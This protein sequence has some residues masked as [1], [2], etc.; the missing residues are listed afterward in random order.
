MDDW[1]I[2][3]DLLENV[4]AVEQAIEKIEYKM[5]ERIN[6]L[7]TLK[8]H[9]ML[10]KHGVLASQI[11]SYNLVAPR[12]WDSLGKLTLRLKDESRDPVEI[13]L[14][15][16][17]YISEAKDKSLADFTLLVSLGFK[18]PANKG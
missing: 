13:R 14:A 11:K 7:A 1:E 6:S 9:A 18:I 17:S 4:E 2:P 15:S 3:G 5:R 8:A 10:A 12:T 16:P